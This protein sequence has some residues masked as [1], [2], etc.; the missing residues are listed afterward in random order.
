MI[1]KYVARLAAPRPRALQPVGRRA[2]A[3]NSHHYIYRP[4]GARDFRILLL[5]PGRYDDGLSAKLKHVSLDEGLTPPYKTT[6][7]A[8]GDAVQR[9]TMLVDGKSMGIS[10]SASLLLRQVRQEHGVSTL[11]V[12][13][14]CIDQSSIGERSQQVSLMVDIYSQGSANIVCLG[15]SDHYTA[16]ALRA[17]AAIKI[18][19]Q[20]QNRDTSNIGR[21]MYTG[22]AGEPRHSAHGSSSSQFDIE[23]LH[24]LYRR[25]WFSR[26]WI[27]Q[28]AVLSPLSICICGQHT[29]L[30]FDLLAAAA[31]VIRSHE[32]IP[33]CR[34]AFK[35]ADYLFFLIYR[36][37]PDNVRRLMVRQDLSGLLYISRRFAVSV[38]QDSVFALLGLLPPGLI[39]DS[40]RLQF[41]L[42]PDYTKSV[43]KVLTDAS[44]AALTLGAPGLLLLGFIDHKNQACVTGEN[45]PSWVLD[46]HDDRSSTEM[47]GRL[48]PKYYAGRGS[49]SQ[50]LSQTSSK[51]LAIKGLTLDQV[52]AVGPVC[53]RATELRDFVQSSANFAGCLLLNNAYGKELQRFARTLVANSV[54]GLRKRKSMQDLLLAWL[55]SDE[56]NTFSGDGLTQYRDALIRTCF[57]RRV[58]CTKGGMLGLGPQYMREGDE[59]V[60]LYKSWWPS[61]VRPAG[62]GKHHHF[63]GSC[64]VDGMMD[65]QAFQQYGSQPD[66]HQILHLR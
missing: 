19:I 1:W 5:E 11:W 54:R 39:A 3:T 2:I 44:R 48:G 33:R 24:S 25:P 13:A 40:P 51:V 7:Y 34:E 16:A 46:L 64:F 59:V 60:V 20:E 66:R 12:D 4:L 52:I 32:V 42:R 49:P 22:S 29:V 57:M 45:L 36:G 41:L 27:I 61:I 15:E 65:G 10:E 14:I 30:L 21:L 35:L 37:Y 9:C 58:F 31:H 53:T 62:D 43:A 38:P 28:E 55:R 6:S 63:V 17:V 26:L 50:N 23:A 47:A 56:S 18:E 8:W